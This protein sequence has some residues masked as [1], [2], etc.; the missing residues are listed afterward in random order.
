MNITIFKFT[1]ASTYT[2]TTA[3]GAGYEY[4]GGGAEREELVSHARALHLIPNS[5]SSM[6]TLIA[7]VPIEPPVTAGTVVAARLIFYNPAGASSYFDSAPIMLDDTRPV[8]P[9]L[10]SCS[11]PTGGAN[12]RGSVTV[13]PLVDGVSAPVGGWASELHA[14]QSETAGITLCWAPGDFEDAESGFWKFE[15]ELATLANESC[16]RRASS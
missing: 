3:L 15:Y 10:R 14:V 9:T 12:Q 1:G 6:K 16:E 11:V 4:V 2:G 5:L 7:S 13:Y 8:H